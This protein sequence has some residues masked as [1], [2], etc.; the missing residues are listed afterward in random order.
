MIYRYIIMKVKVTIIFILCLFFI[1]SCKKKIDQ[2]DGTYMPYIYSEEVYTPVPKGYEPFYINYIGR[3]GSRYPITNKD[4]DLLIGICVEAEEESLLTDKG[5]NLLKHLRLIKDEFNS[6]WG[7][8]TPI[9]EAELIGIASRMKKN[10]PNLFTEAVYVQADSVERC[11]KS[12]EVFINE[13]FTKSEKQNV[14]IELLPSNNPVLNFFNVNLEYVKY[15]NSGVWIEA[16]NQFADSLEAK[17][18]V[19]SSIFDPVFL[20]TV[21]DKSTIIHS[22]YSTYAIIGGAS[23]KYSLR[24]YMTLES[25]FNMWQ[26][27]N[28]RQYTEK[29]P[30]PV[31]NELSIKISFPLLIDFLETTN[32]AIVEGN[33]SADFRFAHAETIIPFAALL[34]I[35]I[36]SSQTLD[37]D[38][39]IEL[40]KDYEIAPMAA[41]IQWIVYNNKEDEY[42]IKM[43]LN[44]KE[45]TFPIESDIEPYY[46]WDD[47][48]NY[49][50]NVIDSLKLIKTFSIDKK[51]KYFKPQ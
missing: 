24:N 45:V 49:Y 32:N 3:H 15:K 19:L 16:T 11:R 10:F 31:N 51:L 4:I 9:G 27:E 17:S 37:L 28:V 40:W 39:L 29:G 21:N 2:M 44:E 35:D 1:C 23:N 18:K 13:L 22:L 8:I 14:N 50:Q 38:L 20:E 30:Y 25:I 48:A 43:L 36:A 6:K 26:I 12:M 47:V 33:V 34:G 7:Q 42:I 5:K 46:K 41:N